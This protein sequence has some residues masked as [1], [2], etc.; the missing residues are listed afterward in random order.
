MLAMRRRVQRPAPILAPAR[1]TIPSAPLSS[2]NQGAAAVRASQ[3]TNRIRVVPAL[4][5]L[6]L[7][8]TTT[9]CPSSSR[10]ADS[11]RPMYPDPPA[12]RIF[13]LLYGPWEQ[14]TR[15][16]GAGL[17]LG[18]EGAHAALGARLIQALQRLGDQRQAVVLTTLAGR[19]PRVHSQPDDLATGGRGVR[20][21]LERRT[22]PIRLAD[23]HGSLGLRVDQAEPALAAIGETADVLP[24]V[25]A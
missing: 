15:R 22:E 8:K 16:S 2:L 11:R 3:V 10:L 9:S 17:S 24:A 14:S 25:P 4:S 12:I 19:Y 5:L 18:L 7:D 1:F 13:I 23:G 20:M 21:L 6:L